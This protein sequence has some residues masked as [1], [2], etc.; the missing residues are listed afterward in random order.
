MKKTFTT[1]AIIIAIGLAV[2]GAYYGYTV[3][4]VV[5]IPVTET[6]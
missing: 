3:Y 4:Q 6:I 1:I 5:E 2:Y